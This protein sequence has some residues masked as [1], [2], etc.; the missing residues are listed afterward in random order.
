MDEQ[1]ADILNAEPNAEAPYVYPGTRTH[2]NKFGI[3]NPDAL[4][5][6]VRAVSE[7]RGQ[8][9]LQQPV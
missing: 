6:V 5:R 3:L 4:E 2:I 9:L 7:L 1:L 8:L